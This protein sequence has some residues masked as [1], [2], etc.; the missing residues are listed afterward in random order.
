MSSRERTMA[1]GLM[2]LILL[3]G[4]V[5][6]GYAF[7][8]QPITQMNA[9]ANTL[10]ADNAKKQ[11]EYD[12][13]LAEQ[14][15]LAILRK[16]SLPPDQAIA[17]REYSEMMARLLLQSRVPPGFRI[18]EISPD[19]TGT[20][21]LAPKKFAYTKLSFEITFERADMWMIHDFLEAYYKLDL[22]QQI[23]SFEIK[24]DLPPVSAGRVRSTT[25]RRD[26]AV[27]FITEAIILDGA[28]ARR[29]LLAVPTAFAAVGGLPGYNAL[30]LTPEASRG[31]TPIQFGPVLSTA[32][33]DYRLIVQNDIFHGPLPTAPSIGIEKLADVSIEQDNEI[34]PVKVKITGDA[35]VGVKLEAKAETGFRLFPEKS[36]KVNQDDR[37]ITFTP[38][39]G[40]TGRSKIRVS[41]IQ[42]DGKKVEATFTIEVKEPE[43]SAK[44]EK[45]TL[46]D[47]SDS[48]KLI[49]AATRS[50]GTASAIVRD[51][52]NPLTYEIEVTASGR[53]KVTKY[54]HI[55]ARKK[56]DRTY[57]DPDLLIFSDDG[58]SSTKRTFKVIAIDPD[59]LVIQDL[60][61]AKAEEKPKEKPKG[62]P[63]RPVAPAK[64]E[65]Q[66][67]AEPL[68]LVV[69][70]AATAIAPPADTG[71]VLYRWA[72]GGS[73]EKIKA[74]PKDEAKKILQKA[75]ATGP[76]GATA[77]VS[78]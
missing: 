17:R 64:P 21:L 72:L 35:S 49:I 23:T 30:V 37:T 11:K 9:Q 6:A 18:R 8:Y 15:R 76:V 41:A 50:D 7:V 78:E 1:I 5:A 12:E 24:T 66:G 19:P 65:K 38:T 16:R 40:E 14:R 26:L 25:D 71:P 75:S 10:A 20:P 58:V 57:D 47:I 60:K 63:V 68:A 51:N 31:L 48:I 59:G 4:S 52:F 32:N 27:K 61:P 44:E 34:P 77:S 73:L 42:D 46:P 2:A 62:G 33:R 53:V 28:E 36:I 3:F 45:K 56:K 13:L 29:T 39:S 22:L 74:L 69:G 55:G 54:D 67:T 43:T 70:V